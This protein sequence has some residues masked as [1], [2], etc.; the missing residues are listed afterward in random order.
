MSYGLSF[1]VIR[2]TC[3]LVDSLLLFSIAT[4]IQFVHNKYLLVDSI[5]KM[6]FEWIAELVQSNTDETGRNE[7]QEGHKRVYA[8]CHKRDHEVMDAPKK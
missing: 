5:F 3:W 7:T 1:L 6:V 8:K 2:F 4:L